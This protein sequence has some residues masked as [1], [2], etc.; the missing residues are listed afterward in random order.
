MAKNVTFDFIFGC[1]SGV[2]SQ[3]GETSLLSDLPYPIY[4]AAYPF[5]VL[6]KRLQAQNYFYDLGQLDKTRYIL[7]SPSFPLIVLKRSPGMVEKNCER[8]GSFSRII[9]GG[10][11]EPDKGKKSRRNLISYLSRDL[12]LLAPALL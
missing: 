6:R 4:L 8:W 9:Q 10:L 12:L 3:I 7:I 5:D 11:N 1:F 2:I